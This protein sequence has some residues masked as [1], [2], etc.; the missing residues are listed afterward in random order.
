MVPSTVCSWR[1]G[2]GSGDGGRGD[3]RAHGAARSASAG[4]T[5]RRRV[6][7]ARVARRF[8]R[9][10][11]AAVLSG[12]ARRRCPCWRHADRRAPAHRLG[13]RPRSSALDRLRTARRSRCRPVGPAAGHVDGPPVA[14]GSLRGLRA[15]TALCNIGMGAQLV[16][17][18]LLVTGWLNAGLAGYAAAATA[19]TLGGLA[20]GPVDGRLVRR[21]GPVRAVLLAGIVRTGHRADRGRRP[22][23]HRVGPRRTAA[24]HRRLLRPR[25]RRADTR[26]PPGRIC[27][28]P[29]RPRHSSSRRPLIN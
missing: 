9:L 26:T 21:I 6:G 11:S 14:R 2:R 7:H 28:R 12:F 24:A 27:C 3:G 16:T 13:H 20:G 17:L 25:R 10:W 23:G 19:V 18:I 22:G 15:A 8:R 1:T 4:A 5:G 29:A